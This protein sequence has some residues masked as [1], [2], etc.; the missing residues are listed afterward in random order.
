MSLALRR[1]Q[2]GLETV[3][4]TPV[5]ADKIL[6]GAIT[7]TPH[8]ELNEPEDEERNSLALTHQSEIVGQW[9]TMRFDANCRFQQIID[10]LAMTLQGGVT[11]TTP[12]GGT[13]SRLWTF[14]PTLDALNVQDSYTF[15]VGDSQQEYEC[16]F[17]VGESMELTYEFNQPIKISASLFGEYLAKS[18]FTGSL[19]IPTLES[20]ITAKTK[21]YIDSS[22]ANLGT[23]Q[24]T[25][26]L[27]SARITL[28]SGL[29]RVWTGEGA[30]DFSTVSENKRRAEI[31]LLLVHNAS[32]V[33]EYDKYVSRALN[34][35]RLETEGSIIEGAI[36]YTLTVDMA[37][38][39]NGDPNLRDQHM[40]LNAIRLT[41][42]SFEDPTSGN[43]FQVSV[44]N[45]E[46]AL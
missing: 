26:T 7:L 36:P 44:I 39:Y 10:L 24:V 30:L 8:L 1:I 3:R 25:G 41:G 45:Q 6:V 19:T 5:A 13:N 40:G 14:T 4:G 11:P 42:A 18:T 27:G 28:P 2:V 20:A 9:T 31:E 29:Q 15:E 16:G 21:L 32:G 12:G 37:L 38:R 43:D 22:W 23:T 33:A 46:T 34:F 35:V 17:V